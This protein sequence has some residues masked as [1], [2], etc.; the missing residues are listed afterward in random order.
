[1]KLEYIITE[2]DLNKNIKDILISKMHISHRLLTTLKKEKSIFLN[3]KTFIYSTLKVG[4]K[5]TI[6][7]DYEEDNSN[8][9]PVKMDLNIVYEDDWII[10]INKPAGIPVHPS[11][12]HYEDSLS[13]GIRYYFDQVGLK[14]KIRPITRIDKDTSGLVIFSKCEYIQEN[15]KK[16]ILL[17]L[18]DYLKIKK[19]LLMLLLQEKKIVL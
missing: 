18:M 7:F 9:I 4:D 19:I 2:A 11:I 10:V 5:I 1:M 3:E 6:S 8:I 17:L 15:L 14:K 13:N 16:S 12:L